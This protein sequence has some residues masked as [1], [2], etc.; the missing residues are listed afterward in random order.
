MMHARMDTSGV[1]S[2]AARWIALGVGLLFAGLFA[3][4]TWEKSLS[5]EVLLSHG[6]KT[7]EGVLK[8]PKRANSVRGSTDWYVDFSVRGKDYQG[9]YAAYASPNPDPS[10]LYPGAKLTVYYLEADPKR[11]T[12]GEPQVLARESILQC[13]GIVVVFAALA[14]TA[15]RQRLSRQRGAASNSLTS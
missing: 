14:L 8:S 3:L 1:S 13:S 2:Q 6:A 10:T 12:L 7:A 5:T 11:S 4:N 9:A 15:G